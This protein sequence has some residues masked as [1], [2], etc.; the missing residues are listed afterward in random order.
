MTATEVTTTPSVQRYPA[1]TT[2]GVIS[3]QALTYKPLT[4]LSKVRL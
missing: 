1:A 2:W 4:S 3:A